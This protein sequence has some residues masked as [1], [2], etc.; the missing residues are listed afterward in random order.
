MSIRSTR[1]LFIIALLMF[2][3]AIPH[4]PISFSQTNQTSTEEVDTRPIRDQVDDKKQLVRDYSIEL[5]ELN[6]ER[7]VKQ[8]EIDNKIHDLQ[9]IKQ[10]LAQAKQNYDRNPVEETRVVLEETRTEYENLD[11]EIQSLRTSFE[12]FLDSIYDL[13]NKIHELTQDIAT[14]QKTTQVSKVS[15]RGANH[16]GIVLSNTC[17]TMIKNNLDSNCPTYEELN[18]IFPDTSNRQV[19]GDFVFKDGYFQRD[20][21]SMKN[22]LNYYSFQD[23]V[24]TW[25]DPPGDILNNIHVITIETSLPEYKIEKL[26]HSLDHNTIYLGHDRHVDTRCNKASITATDWLFLT[27]DTMRFMSNDCDPKFTTFDHV[28]TVLQEKTE[29]DISTSYKWKLDS[30]LAEIKETCRGLCFE[31]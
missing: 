4:I 24:V 20:I 14:L 12:T 28:K 9:N 27:G 2:G 7:T 16:Y 6:S 30:W 26:S 18:T 13:E 15:S 29:F 21:T 22:H 19:S 25:I 3:V 17:I 1:T 5:E 8:S 10:R 11:L 31:Y 23:R